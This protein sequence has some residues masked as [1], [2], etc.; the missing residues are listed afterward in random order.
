MGRKGGG[1]ELNMPVYTVGIIT[2]L[3]DREAL[4]LD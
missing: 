3:S 1:T 4:P 2:E